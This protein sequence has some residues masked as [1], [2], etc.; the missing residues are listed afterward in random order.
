[1]KLHA[2]GQVFASN[3]G[4]RGAWSRVGRH[5]LL[6]VRPCC[7]CPLEAGM[8]WTGPCLPVSGVPLTLHPGR[9]AARGSQSGNTSEIRALGVCGWRRTHAPSAGSGGTS[10]VLRFRPL[11]AEPPFSGA[12]EQEGGE[13]RPRAG[14]TRVRRP[15][16]SDP[17]GD[18]SS[19]H[20]TPTWSCTC[21]VGGQS[22]PRP[23]VV[24]QMPLHTGT[25][26]GKSPHAAA[27]AGHLWTR[28][29]CKH[30][31]LRTGRRLETGVLTG[32]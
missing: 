24:G 3:T 7:I 26:A 1:M 10:T 8:C 6:H 22:H 19:G 11:H 4:A 21:G 28:R 30:E 2:Q 32:A 12:G 29:H 20:V 14:C 27:G 17:S 31:S 9:A 25:W 18:C 23:A 13:R 5:G 15:Q 16:K